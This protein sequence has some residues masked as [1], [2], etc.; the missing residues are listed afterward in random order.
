MSSADEL[1]GADVLEHGLTG[2]NIAGYD[3]EDTV[4]NTRA[5]GSAMQA[6]SKWKAIT[7]TSAIRRK[8]EEERIKQASSWLEHEQ[9]I[10]ESHKPSSARTSIILPRL[11][12]RRR[13]APSTDDHRDCLNPVPESEDK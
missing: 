5:F 10:H 4:K 6:L 7:R 8:E 2:H 13:V 3:V 9:P 12:D 1:I 11:V